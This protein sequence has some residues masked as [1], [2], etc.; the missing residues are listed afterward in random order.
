VDIIVTGAAPTPASTPASTAKIVEIT[1]LGTLS[2]LTETKQ[3]QMKDAVKAALPIISGITYS[4]DLQSV[5]LAKVTITGSECAKVRSVLGIDSGSI[6][7]KVTS[8]GS[9]T[10]AAAQQVKTAVTAFPLSMVVNGQ[11]YTST[12]VAVDVGSPEF[13]SMA[14]TLS[15]KYSML[16]LVLMMLE[17]AFS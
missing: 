12:G 14:L 1:F 5:I 16:G 8:T 13:S 17:F 7:A 10:A 2:S 15:C 3:T 4:I 9:S 11:T 6:I